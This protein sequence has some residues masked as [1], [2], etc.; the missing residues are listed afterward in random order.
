[1][2]KFEDLTPAGND[3]IVRELKALRA[4]VEEL[5]AARSNEATTISAG[6]FVVDR[7]GGFRVLD[8]DTNQVVFYAGVGDTT[9][10]SIVFWNRGDN[11]RFLGV[12][13]HAPGNEQVGSWRD[14]NNSVVLVR[15]DWQ[16][17]GLDRPWL[18]V[19]GTHQFEG[20]ST[21]GQ[22]FQYRSL[23]IAAVTTEQIL[24]EGYIPLL[25]HPR[26]DMVGT[27]GSATGSSNVT[28]TL[29]VRG[30]NVGTWS[31]T[32]TELRTNRGSGGVGS[33]GGFDIS[34]SINFTDVRVVLKCIA[35]GTGNVACEVYSC[36]LR[37]T[38]Q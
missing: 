16:G 12:D 36:Y 33:L 27:W 14:R 5:R 18:V 9:G 24:W 4:E 30:N 28:Y 3:W 22:V 21:E 23:P 34:A 20:V 37:G 13:Y 35:T 17:S 7:D 8:K 1:M 6:R 10:K 11:T 15:D 29:E 2:T 31:T 32:G 38:P 25:T 26:I 19:P